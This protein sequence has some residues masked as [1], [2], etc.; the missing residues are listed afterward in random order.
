LL[1]ILVRMQGLGDRLDKVSKS[2]K[3]VLFCEVEC[4][5]SIIM[6]SLEY[7]V[8]CISTRIKRSARVKRSARA[9]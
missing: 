7:K 3:K 1:E 6:M 8:I 2:R 4:N 5:H 9:K